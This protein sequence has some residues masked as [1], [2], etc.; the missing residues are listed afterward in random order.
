MAQVHQVFSEF[1]SNLFLNKKKF[2]ELKHHTS[3]LWQIW[4]QDFQKVM[5][6]LGVILDNKSQREILGEFAKYISQSPSPPTESRESTP[7]ISRT[8]GISN[9][10][11]RHVD[12]DPLLAE[13]LG[14][15][16]YDIPHFR[17]TLL[18]LP[19]HYEEKIRVYWESCKV[20]QGAAE[21]EFVGGTKGWR[22]W[23]DDPTEKNVGHFLIQMSENILT[24]LKKGEHK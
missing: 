13:E 18:P 10:S 11:E 20:Q 1:T 15:A 17:A 8:S 3:S 16:I 22:G 23:P 2:V 24:A 21:P 4:E 6:L 9:S 7:I 19:K 12:V 5:P 14:T